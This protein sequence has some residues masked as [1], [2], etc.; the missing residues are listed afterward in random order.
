MINFK[1]E[2]CLSGQ[3]GLLKYVP[4]LFFGVI[5]GEKCLSDCNPENVYSEG[6]G[7][8]E[9]LCL[10]KAFELCEEGTLVL[11]QLQITPMGTKIVSNFEPPVV[12]SQFSL[13]DVTR[14]GCAFLYSDCHADKGD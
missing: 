2:K 1:G 7:M 13:L 3:F 9:I 8:P 14:E 11:E 6:M 10:E 4:R 12:D 5:C